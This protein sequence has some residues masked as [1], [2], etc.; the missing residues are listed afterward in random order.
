MSVQTFKKLQ[1]HT[2]GN[3]F[4]KVTHVVEVAYKDLKNKLKPHQVILKVQYVGINASDVNYTNGAYIPGIKPPF[5]VGF[6]GLGVIVEG[7]SSVPKKAIGTYGVFSQYGAFS[8]YII[9]NLKNIIPIPSPKPEYLGLLVSGLTA[10]ISLKE[11]GRLKSGETVLVTA[12]SGGTGQFAVQLAKLSGNHV[13]GT[14]SSDDKVELLKQIGCDR[15]INYKKEDFKKVLKEEYPKGVDIVYES[16]GG[17]F[18][19][20]CLNSLATKGRLIVIGMAS[21]YTKA[22]G[23]KGNDLNTQKLLGKSRTV[24]GFFLN[25]YTSEFPE[26]LSTLIQL[27]SEK[28]LHVEIDMI[29]NGDIN[30]IVTGVNHLQTGKNK[31]K[32]VVPLH[33]SSSK[34]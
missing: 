1:A 31:G 33:S 34:L 20:I 22:S 23:L 21:T 9:L 30:D 25:D 6:E 12:A 15:V 26:H 2:I 18:F 11:N 19:D 29:G 7:G 10:S 14:C 3:N 16:V 24:T 28:K 13:I 17:E 32:V 4:G 8:E 27:L 5:D